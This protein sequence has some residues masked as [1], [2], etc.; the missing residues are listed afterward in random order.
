MSFSF[1]EEKGSVPI[2]IVE[3]TKRTLYLNDKVVEDSF[4]KIDLKSGKL[5]QVPSNNERDVLYI[6]AMSG[7]GKSYYTAEYVKQYHKKYPKNAVYLFSSID[8][9]KC[10]DSLKYLQRFNIKDEM[11]FKTPITAKD[12]E[13]SCVIFDDCD[14]IS[15]KNTKKKIF[16]ILDE[17]LQTGRHFNTTCIFTS[18][19]ATAGNNTK[20]ILNEATSITIFPQTAGNKSLNYL[21]DQYLGLD[22]NQIKTLK[23]GNSRWATFIRSYPRCI[24]TE[25]TAF[26]IKDM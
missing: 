11:F 12:F 13:K 10:L 2:A 8:N 25:T 21:C 18:H 3:G 16:Q 9:D 20:I 14:V 26:L 22:K 24:I 7:S 4:T 17:I 19:N 1:I 23:K 5:Q 6:S 15:D